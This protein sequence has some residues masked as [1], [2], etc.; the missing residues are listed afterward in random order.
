MKKTIS[1]LL[2]LVMVM[3]LSAIAFADETGVETGAYSTNVTGA[4]VAGTTGGTVFSVDIAWSN[5]SFTY[6]AEQEP[7]WN[8]ND[9]TYSEAVDAYWEGEGTITVTNHSNA[10]IS[11]VPVFAA[12]V[13]YNDAEMTFST[14]K[15]RVASAADNNTAQTGTIT[16]TPAGFLP[17]MDKPETIG[18]ITLTIAQDTDVTVE[19]GRAL[20]E[21]A[22]AL[23]YQAQS[24]GAY[25]EYTA[26]FVSLKEATSSLTTIV[27]ELEAVEKDGGTASESQQSWLNR[28]YENTLSNYKNCKNLSGL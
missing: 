25:D 8:V 26:Q 10:K 27:V 22:E 24:T 13:G 6:Y 11:A 5:M 9:H 21:Q 14:D 1:L 28:D 15:L 19:E 18:T 17:E 4:Y 16:V 23:I 20:V 2:A 12:A 7:V 3:S